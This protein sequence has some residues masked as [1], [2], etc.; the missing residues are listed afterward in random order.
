VLASWALASWRRGDELQRQAARRG[1]ATRVAS[2]VE[3]AEAVD[4]EGSGG[5]DSGGHRGEEGRI[6]GD[7][8]REDG[9]MR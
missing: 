6:S 1:G 3:D 2:K 5:R 4:L 7:V 9:K 8:P